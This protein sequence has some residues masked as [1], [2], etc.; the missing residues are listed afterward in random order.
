MWGNVLWSISHFIILFPSKDVMGKMK[1]KIYLL[2]FF[3]QGSAALDIIAGGNM[4][5]SGY[6]GFINILDIHLGLSI[7]LT[8]NL[9]GSFK[10]SFDILNVL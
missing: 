1:H 3:S 4:T 9:L 6:N 7:Y 5:V 8:F 10:F 2:F